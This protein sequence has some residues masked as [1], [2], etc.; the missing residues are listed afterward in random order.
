MWNLKDVVSV[1]V[2]HTRDRLTR[3]VKNVD[4]IITEEDLKIYIDRNV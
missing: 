3:V 4:D 2:E 1:V